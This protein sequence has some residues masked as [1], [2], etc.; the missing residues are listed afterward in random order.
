MTEASGSIR[1]GFR[2][3]RDPKEPAL[4]LPAMISTYVLEKVLRVL[5]NLLS[6]I[7]STLTQL[8]VTISGV[9]IIIAQD[10]TAIPMTL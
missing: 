1:F 8:D 4:G 6:T 3:P 2:V 9:T 7:I 5:W 10:T